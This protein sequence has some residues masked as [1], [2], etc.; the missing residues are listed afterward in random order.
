MQ[1]LQGTTLQYLQIFPADI[2]ETPRRVPVDPCKHLQCTVALFKQPIGLEFTVLIYKLCTQTICMIDKV[3]RRAWGIF[4]CL[5]KPILYS[6]GNGVMILKVNKM[7][8]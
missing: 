1:S 5:K 7:R 3:I 8:C 2:A 6:F 4:F